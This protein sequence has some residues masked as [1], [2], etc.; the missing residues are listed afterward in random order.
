MFILK[1][2][3]NH[4]LD[5]N[6]SRVYPGNQIELEDHWLENPVVK[7][8]LKAGAAIIVSKSDSTSKAKSKQKSE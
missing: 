4:P 2:I 5:I 1:V 7:D 8:L 6:G 3:H